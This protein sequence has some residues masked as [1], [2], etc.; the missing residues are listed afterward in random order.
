[1]R[2]EDYNKAIDYYVEI[3]TKYSRTPQVTS[4]RNGI[5]T[6][7]TRER[8]AFTREMEAALA[9]KDQLIA[10]KDE[11]ISEM[12][13]T[14]IIS[15]ITAKTKEADTQYKKKNYDE[16]RTLYE[17]AL[18]IIPEVEKSHNTILS[19]E[20]NKKNELFA[21]Y[22]SEAE[23]AYKRSNYNIAI[24]NYKKAIKLFP[25]D[26]TLVDTMVLRIMESGYK[27]QGDPDVIA[28]EEKKAND[29]FLTASRELR[30]QNYEAAFDAYIEILT[31]YPRTSKASNAQN[32]IKTTI[33]R[34]ITALIAEKNEIKE[35][36][37]KK[38]EQLEKDKA[39]L[40]S[41]LAALQQQVEQGTAASGITVGPTPEPSPLPANIP[42]PAPGTST[43][44][45]ED[46]VIITKEEMEEYNKLKQ[47]VADLKDQYIKYTHEEDRI[48]DKE[49]SV[50]YLRTK[51]ILGN[52]LHSEFAREI[53]PDLYERLKKFDDALAE[54]ARADGQYLAVDNILNIIYD[55]M[56]LDSDAEISKYWKGLRDKYKDDSLF[57]ELLDELQDMMEK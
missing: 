19:M 2:D 13:K 7:V 44:I 55:R 12:D 46:E 50:G 20:D 52:L 54:D 18:G 41:E 51:T 3:L 29:L 4:A 32:G 56:I 35:E 10:E 45:S 5:N 16:A 39:N 28:E 34:E 26:K 37:T 27:L 38:I 24:D 53:F 9:E 8:D 6:A 48:I 33:S 42:S 15:S 43:T 17:Q 36:F 47:Q 21:S 40:E 11:M 1:L 30:E 31:H 57:L 25:Q 22:Y 14:D 23:S 49:G